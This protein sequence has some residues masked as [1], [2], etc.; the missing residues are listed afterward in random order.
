MIKNFFSLGAYFYRAISAE[1]FP[2]ASKNKH[3]TL[4]NLK[5]YAAHTQSNDKLFNFTVWWEKAVLN[6]KKIKQP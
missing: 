2:S 1:A 5:N 6:S 3:P 4:I